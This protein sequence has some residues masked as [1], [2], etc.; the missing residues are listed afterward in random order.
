MS[1]P[2]HLRYVAIALEANNSDN[3]T[4]FHGRVE[5]EHRPFEVRVEPEGADGEWE[6]ACLGSQLSVCDSPQH[7]VSFSGNG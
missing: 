2:E 5:L 7:F 3:L 6:Q 4:L 1:K